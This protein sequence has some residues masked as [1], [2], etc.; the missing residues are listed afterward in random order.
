MEIL[1]LHHNHITP[2]VKTLLTEREV[3]ELSERIM[4]HMSLIEKYGIYA[5]NCPD[6]QVK[7]L[8]NRHQQVM[9][10]H[11]QTMVGFMQNSQNI[12]AGASLTQNQTQY[13]SPGYTF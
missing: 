3:L 4:S 6:Q 7:D 9:Q 11:F 12:T 13:H 1:K 2:E 5:R 10:N 8:I